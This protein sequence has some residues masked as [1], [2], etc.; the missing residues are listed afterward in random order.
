MEYSLNDLF[1]FT[2]IAHSRTLSEGARKLNISQPSLTE[3]I[4]RLENSLGVVLF[5][6]SRSGIQ[7]T[8]DGRELLKRAKTLK[9]NYEDIRSFA[10]KESSDVLEKLKLGAHSTVAQYL[11][12][13]TFQIL[14]ESSPQLQIEMIHDLSRNIQ[15]KVQRGEIDIAIV[16]NPTRVPDL[17]IKELA[18]DRVGFFSVKKDGR[19]D[20]KEQAII[21]NTDLY[22]TQSLL[23][24]LKFTP[25]KL[26][27]TNSLELIARLS[28]EDVGIGIIP[29]RVAKMISSK[30]KLLESFPLIKD[31]ITLVY[32]PEFTK[33]RFFHEIVE[34]I[35]KSL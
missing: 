15:E 2:E 24:K 1:H 28:E 4:K 21:C 12:P 9:N 23:K 18:T 11:F 5:Y 32:R 19:G 33:N 35:K 20:F 17:V 16:I 13:K 29:E 14:K 3:S 34:A 6:R 31:E 8:Q 10:H 27:T 22:Q 7:L 26:M 25:K 30:L